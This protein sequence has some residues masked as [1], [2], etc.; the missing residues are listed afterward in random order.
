MLPSASNLT[1]IIQAPAWT[2]VHGLDSIIVDD[3]T[4]WKLTDKRT[5]FILKI[6]IQRWMEPFI[7]FLQSFCLEILQIW[8]KRTK[9][10][11][12]HGSIRLCIHI[13]ISLNSGNVWD[14]RTYLNTEMEYTWANKLTSNLASTIQSCSWPKVKR[15]CVTFTFCPQETAKNA[16]LHARN[17]Y[18]QGT[19]SYCVCK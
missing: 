1:Y 4:W 14:G 9:T 6:Q 7:Y 15:V 3:N 11:A 16:K 10:I 18:Y 17:M 13:W 19:W 12:N 8:P 5:Q 2:H